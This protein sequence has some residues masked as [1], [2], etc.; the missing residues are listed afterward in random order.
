M[1]SALDASFASDPWLAAEFER[2]GHVIFD[3]WE[4]ANV[5]RVDD[6]I[7]RLSRMHEDFRSFVRE[8]N[9]VLKARIERLQAHADLLSK[10]LDVHDIYDDY[11]PE[12]YAHDL[13]R[14]DIED[15]EA[16]H[17]QGLDPEAPTTSA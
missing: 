2:V 11:D 4:T 15:R 13:D 10:W 14:E 9:L 16:W 12:L 1:R 7:E 5:G 8:L 6:E 17:P 3:L